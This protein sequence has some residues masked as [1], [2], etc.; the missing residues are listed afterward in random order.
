MTSD[1]N[2]VAATTD[3]FV[4]QLFSAAL[5]TADVL[6]VYIGDQLGYY[7]AM[8]DGNAITSRELAVRAGTSER[9]AREFLEAQAISG[10]IAVENSDAGAEERRYIL[11]P[12]QAEV[13]TADRSLSYLA[14]LARMLG[15]CGVNLNAIVAAHRTGGGVS[16]DEFGDVMRDAQGEMNRPAFLSVLGDEWVPSVAAVHDRL[17]A[18]GRVADVGTGHGWSAIGLAEAYPDISV[19]GFDVDAPSIVAAQKHA[20]EHGVDDRVRFTTADVVTEADSDHYDVVTAFECIHDMP[21]PVSVLT[22]MRRMVKDDGVVIVM[23]ENVADEFG[24]FGDE[25]ERLMY[26]FSNLVCLPD[27]MSHPGSVG[28]GTVIRHATMDRY[29]REAGF[30]GADVL[31]I[32]G[33]FWRF[34]RLTF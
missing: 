16:W 30:S 34:Y 33:G 10:Y 27:G 17:A 18:G 11:P 22:A 15:I 25:V 1:S 28:T 6:T 26:G 29:A 5:A 13:L 32:D 20:T 2:L 24:A 7:R 19:H 8:A 4:E 9:Y 23:D 21:D 12:G 3:E 14:P 31:P